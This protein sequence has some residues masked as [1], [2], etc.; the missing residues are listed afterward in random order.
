M[1]ELITLICY[2]LQQNYY[3]FNVRCGTIINE[4]FFIFV[5]HLN[6]I[7]T[8]E[9]QK[10][11]PT[12]CILIAR[13]YLKEVMEVAIIIKRYNFLIMYTRIPDELIY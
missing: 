2:L 11:L 4:H 7:Q 12:I 9:Q 1:R 6:K 5:F 13:S 10:F 3:Y 8:N